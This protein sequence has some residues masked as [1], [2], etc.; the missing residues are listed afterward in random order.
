MYSDGRLPLGLHACLLVHRLDHIVAALGPEP[1][2][3]LSVLADVYKLLANPGVTHAFV[4]SFT[5]SS[6]S[7]P[8]PSSGPSHLRD[9]L[10]L[11]IPSF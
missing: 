9:T 7:P 4:H 8:F 5:P 2:S 1:M 11:S 6:T 10:S 3:L